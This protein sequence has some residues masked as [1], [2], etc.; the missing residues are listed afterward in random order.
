MTQTTERFLAD[1]ARDKRTLEMFRYLINGA[2]LRVVNYHN[3]NP[4]S[5]EQLEAEIRYYSE[6]FVPV[7]LRDLDAFF[8]T[9]KWPYDRP[10]LIPA[11]FEGFRNQYDV[12]VPLLNKYHFTGWFYIPS[13]YMDVPVPEQAAYSEAHELDISD[14]GLYPDGRVAM[15]WDEVR[16]IASRHEICCHTG[17]HFQI[18]RES[19]EEEMRREI[20]DA[21]RHLEAQ[22][23]R[24]VKVF[25]WLYG[26]EYRYN[27]RAHRYLE[28][29]GYEY[30]LSN[31]KL[32]KIRK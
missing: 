18:T 12:L 1:V 11:V 10:G 22:I 31:L 3:T 32:E 5:A 30:V 14:H 29:A 28:E 4:A 19:S 23:G 16:E 21:K 15:T 27:A 17:T 9:R 6:H 8:T 25:C 2:Y 7:T 13:Y 26:E 24:E 20:V